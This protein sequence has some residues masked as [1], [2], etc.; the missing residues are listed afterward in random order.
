[1]CSLSLADHIQ[2]DEVALRRL[3]SKLTNTTCMLT[4]VGLRRSASLANHLSHSSLTAWEVKCLWFTLLHNSSLFK[5]SDQYQTI[6]LIIWFLF[7]VDH[8]YW[9]AE[10]RG[11][12][13]GFCL[14]GCTLEAWH[15]LWVPSALA[16]SIALPFYFAIGRSAISSLL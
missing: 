12:R 4:Q 9:L 15:L 7:L 16:F 2:E 10:S 5:R 14:Q 13:T 11:S 6:V 8:H 3:A 1:M